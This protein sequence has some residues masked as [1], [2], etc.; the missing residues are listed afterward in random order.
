MIDASFLHI[1]LLQVIPINA[2]QPCLLNMSAGADMWFNCGATTDYIKFALLP[3][4]WITG[5][6]FPI[7]VC[8]TLILSS[9]LLYHKT[10][11]P[12]LIGIAFLPISAALFPEQFINF[13]IIMAM[14]G[15]GMLLIHIVVSRTTEQ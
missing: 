2:T 14:L 1:I 7:I 12:I 4:M 10:V 11:Y 8:A 3:F 5:G 15:L 13:A 9:W 6:Y